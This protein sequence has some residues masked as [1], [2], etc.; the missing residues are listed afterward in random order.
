MALIRQKFC[1]QKQRVKS[2]N[3]KN[4]RV[5]RI[6]IS[7]VSF[8]ENSTLVESLLNVAETVSVEV[9][10]PEGQAD[11]GRILPL[12]SRSH[13]RSTANHESADNSYEATSHI[14]LK[15]T[16]SVPKSQVE[17]A[18]IK[19]HSLQFETT[20]SPCWDSGS[21]VTSHNLFQVFPPLQLRGPWPRGLLHLCIILVSAY[22]STGVMLFENFCFKTYRKNVK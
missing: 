14:K 1:T 10:T 2:Q 20:C 19:K 13:P 15:L 3:I 9:S 8:W 6:S 17:R 21:T 7:C 5:K 4:L 11:D 16:S 12:V 18:K 22:V